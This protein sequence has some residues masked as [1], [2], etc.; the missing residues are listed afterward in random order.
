MHYLIVE[1]RIRL[2]NGRGS[3]KEED[4]A[5]CGAERG[6]A[7]GTKAKVT[8]PECKKLLRA[9]KKGK[10]LLGLMPRRAPV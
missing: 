4:L 8:C 5:L 7:C 2:V 9:N 6:M 10:P 3:I 1:T